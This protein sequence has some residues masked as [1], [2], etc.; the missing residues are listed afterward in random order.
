MSSVLLNA[1][2][3]TSILS[4]D[5]IGM[6][7]VD[8]KLEIFNK[9]LLTSFQKTLRIDKINNNV[10]IILMSGMLLWLKLHPNIAGIK[11]SGIIQTLKFI[12]N[13]IQNV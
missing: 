12:T 11:Q 13:N 1:V 5:E 4:A 8:L 10:Y 6:S 7:F 9:L 3:F 2:I